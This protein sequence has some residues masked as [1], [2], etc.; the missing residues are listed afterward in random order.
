M[1]VPILKKFTLFQRSEESTT[2]NNVPLRTFENVTLDGSNEPQISASQAAFY[3]DVSRFELF[4][5]A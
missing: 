2:T 4:S 3:N 5:H 1:E